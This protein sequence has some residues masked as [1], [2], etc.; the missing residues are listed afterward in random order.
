MLTYRHGMHKI[1]IFP[2]M[3]TLTSVREAA[4][5]V[6]VKTDIPDDDLV[7][8]KICCNLKVI[9]KYCVRQSLYYIIIDSMTF[10]L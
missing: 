10:L 5:R 8:V 7:R 3:Y 2:L 9:Q 1:K 4:K 6:Y